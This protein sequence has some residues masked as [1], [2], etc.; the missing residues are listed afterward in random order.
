MGAHILDIN[1]GTNGIDEKEMMLKAISKVTM[2][3]SLP[4]CIDTSYVEVMEAALR[5]YPGRALINSISLETE[6]I[7]KL[8]PLAKKYGAMFILLPLSDEGLPKSL[9]EKKEIINTI[10]EKAKKLGVSKNQIIVDGLVTTVGANKNAA[11]ETL[12]TIRYCKEDLKLCT[13]MGLSNISFGLPERPYV[14]GAFASMAIAS[15]LTMAI[16]NPSNQLL[17]GISFA[18]DLLRNKEG[19]DIAYIEQIQRMEPLKEAAIAKAAKT[20]GNGEKQPNEKNA[21][22]GEADG[23]SSANT[24]EQAVEYLEPLLKEGGIQEK[25]PTIIIAT[26][27]GDIHDIGKNLVALMLRNYGYDVIDLGKDVPADEIIAAAK[28]H[29]ASIIV[30]SALMTTTMMRMKDTIALKEKEHLD[31][32]VMIGGAVTT[33]SFADEI[34]ADGYSAD[35]ADAVRLAKKLLAE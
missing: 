7:E 16:A 34:G 14:N 26:V 8:L 21:A 12:E 20:A 10:L 28:E 35:A 2:V 30:L 17:M 32:K 5:A 33:Q 1:M 19:S 13:T 18:S 4:L 31:V 24:M 25:M 9:A 11:L 29:N 22:V 23:N 27:E 15:G 6:K 3:S